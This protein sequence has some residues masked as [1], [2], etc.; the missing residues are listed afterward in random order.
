VQL[1]EASQRTCFPRIHKDRPV[2]DYC[3]RAGAEKLADTI[4]GYWLVRG[5]DVQIH[6]EESGFVAVMRSART[7][8]RSDMRNGLPRKPAS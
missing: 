3:S 4:R 5:F 7:D 8:I 2:S 6:Y 1:A